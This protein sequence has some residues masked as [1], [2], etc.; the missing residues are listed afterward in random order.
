MILD[1][2]IMALLLAVGNVAFRHFEP[3]MPWW[4]RVVKTILILAATAAISHY[5]GRT[6][7]LIGLG[8]ALAALV[9]VHGIWLPRKGVNGWT[10]EPREKYYQLRGW[11]PPQ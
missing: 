4:R 10:A 3:F 2:C 9:Y 7:F 11:P 6:G 1:I 5:F 8:L